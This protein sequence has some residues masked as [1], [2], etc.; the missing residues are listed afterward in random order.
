MSAL[1]DNLNKD[2]KQAVL[3]YEGPALVLAG[4]GSGKTRVLTTRV[5][6][7]IEE[8]NISPSN[9]LLVTFTNKAAHEMNKRVLDLTGSKLPF[10]G[11]F[12]SLCAKILRINGHK[13]GL[14]NYFVIYDSDEQLELIKQ[15]Y[16]DL[17]LN[18]KE[19]NPR[20][21]HGTISSAKNEMV[22]A[23]E[24]ERLATGK[25]QETVA[26]VY[27]LYQHKL[28]ENQ[29]VDFDDLL[30]LTNQL[31]A[32]DKPTLAYY[33]DLIKFVL[34]DEYQDTNKV[35][36]QLTKYLAKPQNNLFVVGDFSQSIYA[37]RGADYKNMMLL[38]NDFPDLTEYRLEQNYRSTQSILDAAT[39]VISHNKSH[40]ILSLWTENISDA[41]IVHLEC[42]SG[43]SE[44]ME[45]VGKIK[46]LIDYNYSDVAILYR[47]NAQSRLFEEACV[48][49]GVPYKLVGGF[50]FYE[51]KEIK[52]VLSYLKLAI[53]P[54]DT[55]SRDRAL[56]IG[57]RR[58][59]AFEVA[60]KEWKL[61]ELNPAELLEKILTATTYRDKYNQKDEDDLDKLNNIKELLNVAAQFEKVESLLENI[62][63]VQDNE[64]ADQNLDEPRNAITMMS[65]HSAKGLE[66]PVVFM[67]GMEEGLLPHSRALLDKEQM[68]EERRLCYVG[69]TRAREKLILSNARHRFVYGS[70]SYATI[71]RFLLDIDGGII[72]KEGKQSFDYTQNNHYQGNKNWQDDSKS[73]YDKSSF[74]LPKSQSD[75]PKRRLVIDDDSWSSFMN[76]EFD[77]DKILDI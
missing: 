40:P 2:Q 66:F 52:D 76:G 26:R 1:L 49:K 77:A 19:I 65:L 34:V 38:K 21:V 62:A 31:F 71:S 35:Q 7:L 32:Q 22:S 58:F 37:W 4:A 23:E 44:A 75:K 73:F 67:V 33:Q 8:K 54:N 51:R 17:N 68:E 28:K 18:V 27:K 56:K 41:K 55:V 15:V 14:N 20:A 64:M 63:L 59:I 16:A 47:T 29:A 61:D 30:L 36:Y 10:S 69:I 60:S 43:E 46:N 70:G 39:Q 48:K 74:A 3:H 50:K 13:I 24:Y 72:K 9:I 11:T 45:V 53:N 5:A 57:K 25:Y 6:Y 42:E 12:H